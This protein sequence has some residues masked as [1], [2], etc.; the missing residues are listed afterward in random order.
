M[1][2]SILILGQ[3]KSRGVPWRADPSKQ[4]CNCL[5]DV[6]EGDSWPNCSK[7]KCLAMHDVQEYL[8]IKPANLGT[9]C[10]IY[11]T[12]GRCPRGLACRC[13]NDDFIQLLN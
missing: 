5:I 10:Y 1:Y 9:S 8:K 3:N 7:N 12:Y 6:L 13:V 11:R 4:L 2:V